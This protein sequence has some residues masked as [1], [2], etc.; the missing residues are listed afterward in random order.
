MA[1][2]KKFSN[3]ADLV[4]GLSK[5]NGFRDE[6]LKEFNDTSLSKCLMALRCKSKLTQEKMAAKVGCTQSKISKIEH[7][8]NEN[9]TVE[10][11]TLYAKACKLQLEIGFRDSSTKLADLIKYHAMK[12]KEY[13]DILTA[14]C[15]GDTVIA[16]G[17]LDFHFE[18]FMVMNQMIVDNI[19]KLT[20]M[21]PSLQNEAIRENLDSIHIS[22]PLKEKLAKSGCST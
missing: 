4:K 19:E 12:T 3:V 14:S 13:L 8:L 9:I 1:N 16:E 18:A 20:N 2:Q 5:D 7:S 6:V 22:S 17:V 11:M 21:I 15:E 10:D